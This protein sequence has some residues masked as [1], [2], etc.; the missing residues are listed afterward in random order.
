MLLVCVAGVQV[1]LVQTAN[2]TPWNDGGFGTFSSLDD[3]RFR[4]MRV[5][6][7]AP[8]RS[9]EVA[10]APSLE[11]LATRAA[12]LPS[13]RGLDHLARA[14]AGRERRLG[15][16]VDTVRVEVWREQFHP[17]TLHSTEHLL[18]TRTWRALP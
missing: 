6:V 2:P 13:N 16:P 3:V 11:D 4:R 10:I 1:M 15:R 18:R 7:E 14:V 8:G 5:I 17:F 12:T 9:E